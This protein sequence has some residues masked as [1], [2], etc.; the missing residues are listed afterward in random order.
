MIKKN[1]L[2][3]IPAKGKSKGLKNKNIRLLNGKPLLYYSLV[4][5][6]KLKINDKVIFC[7]TDSKKIQNICKIYNLKP[8]FLR[9]KKMSSTFSRDIEYV[10][11]AIKKFSDL[12]LK[13][14][15]GLILRPTSPK[16]KIEI[17]QKAFKKF[18]KGNYDSMRSIIEAPYPVD[19]MWYIKKQ[20]LVPII[21]SKIYEN[22]NAPRQILRNSYAQSGNFEFFKINYKI[23]LNSISNKKIG[24]FLTSNELENDI[25]NLKDLKKIKLN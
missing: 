6:K 14:K 23:K 19:K 5:A 10:N 1:L 9:P 24:Y 25:D 8:G 4:V 18:I 12:G 17:I 7:S 11:H 21:K 16:R 2:I 13:F 15:Y 22:Y 20:L 3:I